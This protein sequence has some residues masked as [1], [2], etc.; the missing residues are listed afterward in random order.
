MQQHQ[1][2]VGVGSQV[3]SAVPSVRHQSDSWGIGRKVA[4]LQD[5]LPKIDDECIDKFGPASAGLRAWGAAAMLLFQFA[6]AIRKPLSC[7]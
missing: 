2:G 6:A 3:A 4:F 1:V 7:R 5:P